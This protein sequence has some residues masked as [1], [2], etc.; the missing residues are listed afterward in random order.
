MTEPVQ[1]HTLH[2]FDED[3]GRIRS[4]VEETADLAGKQ[5]LAAVDAMFR[6]DL[7]A[8]AAIALA[9]ARIDALQAE[10]EQFAIATIGRR[11]PMADDLREIISAIK[12][13]GDLERE[14]Y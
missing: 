8:A 11:A 14:C 10:T 1:P 6:R 3:L 5:I 12:I 9:D 2:T 13:A 4:L 7:D